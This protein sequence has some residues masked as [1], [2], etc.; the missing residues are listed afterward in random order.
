MTFQQSRRYDPRGRTTGAQH[1]D[2]LNAVEHFLGVAALARHGPRAALIC[3]AESLSYAELATR[4][5]RAANALRALGVSPGDRVLLL[6]R[7]TP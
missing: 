1:H 6:M 5:A 7:D 2:N 4:V 3:G